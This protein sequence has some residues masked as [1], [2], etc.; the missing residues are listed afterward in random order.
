MKFK[1]ILLMALTSSLALIITGCGSSS[2]GDGGGSGGTNIT[3]IN[4][5]ATVGGLA[6]TQTSAGTMSNGAVT[7]KASCSI[8]AGSLTANATLDDTRD[9]RL[10]GM[11][12]AA[13]SY[14]LTIAAG[15]DITADSGAYIFI[16]TDGT[17]Q[18]NGTG[19]NPVRMSSSSDADFNG[20]GGWGGLFIRSTG[21]NLLD[22]TVVAEGG[23][24]TVVAGTTYTD[25]IVINGATSQTRLTFVQSHDSARDGI[26]LQ[27]TDARLSW[28]LVTGATRDGIWYRDFNGLVKDYLSINRPT[29]GSGRAGIYA[30]RS[31]IVRT[32]NPRFVN[33]TLMGRDD[34][35][36]QIGAD[37]AANEFGILFA[38]NTNQGRFA[39]ILIANYRN[40]CIATSEQADLSGFSTNTGSYF[41]GIHCANEA[42]GNPSFRVN[43]TGTTGLPAGVV[44]ANNSNG[45]GLNY[46]NGAM[47]P[48]NFTGETSTRNF[49]AA[50]YLSGIGNSSPS[51]NTSNGGTAADTNSFDNSGSPLNRFR[52]G[53]TNGSGTLETADNGAT[54][55]LGN[56]TNPFFADVAGDTG[57][58]DLTHIGASRSGSDASAAQ[59]NNWTVQTGIGEGFVP[60][61]Q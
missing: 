43:R 58:Y 59:F 15:T 57:G 39:N 12:R 10:S 22:Y 60:T 20:P 1:K 30:S 9:W 33:V 5:P 42:G 56:T 23:E 16:D 47:N 28:I 46:Y 54:P 11:L 31:T 53:D 13:G 41:D 50:W 27:N 3:A 17:I 45:D 32:S 49:T 34:T 44:A 35:S 21:A 14:S 52:G 51:N 36:V 40:G 37:D 61:R 8:A 24:E 48:I 38:D 25:N 18:S 6:V 29:T 7:T 2:D 4:C 26:R 19:A 55:F